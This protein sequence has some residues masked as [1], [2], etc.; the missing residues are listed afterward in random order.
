MRSR[1]SYCRRAI[2]LALCTA[3]VCAS[4]EAVAEP[5][6][7][8][9][10]AGAQI[11]TDKGCTILKVNFNL[12]VRY[13][14]HF[15]LN[16]GDELR[17]TVQPVDR[18]L[19]AA[20]IRVRREAARVADGTA[21]AIKTIDF[22]ADQPI[23]PVLRIVFEH[24]VAYQVAQGPD[25]ESIIIAIAG[26]RSSPTCRPEIP[27]GAHHARE[28]TGLRSAAA[29]ATPDRSKDRPA[30]K[31]SAANLRIV[32]ASMDEA[33][34]AMRKGQFKTAI[35]LFTKVLQYP[36][37]E[38]SAEAQELLG[39]AYQKSNELAQA[40]SEYED[41]LRRYPSG[42]GNERV[43]QR[44]ASILTA[45]GEPQEK[46]RKAKDPRAE[47]SSEPAWSLFGSVSAF[48]IR[49]DS[50]RM[51]KDPSLPPVP[52]EDKDEHRVHQNMM[53]SSIDLFGT[54]ADGQAK[55]KFRFSGSEEHSFDPDASHR[56]IT[57]VAALYAETLLSDWGLLGRVGRQT[58]NT[59]GVIGRFDGGLLSWQA[60]PA[61]RFNVVGGSPVASRR[62]TVF[63]DQKYFYG[64]SIDFGPLFGGIETSVFAIEQR[65]RSLLDRRSVG[66]EF[67]YFDVKTS[68]LGTVDY[69]VH[70]N[71]LNAAI[72]SGSWTLFDKST[73]Y[74][75]ADYRKA[76][77]LSAWTALQGQPFLT[78]YDMMR[79]YTKEEIDQ[80]AS[81]RTATYKS[82]MIGFSHPLNDK[83]QISADA[84]AVN[85]SGMP[86]SGGV[87]AILP[88]GNEYY[89]SLQ[90]I[91]TGIFAPGDMYIAGFRFA[92]L[93]QSNL[94][95]LDFSARYPLMPEFRISPRLR[96][97]YR[98]GDTTDLKEYTVLPSILL[99]YYLAKDVNLEL[100]VGTKWAELHQ[101]G[102]KETTTNLFLTAG[103]RYDFHVDGKA[104]VPA[105]RSRCTMPWPMC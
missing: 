69:D 92:D 90:L 79:L 48:Y 76:P 7:D 3:V 27:P 60:S 88:V 62:D 95:V 47:R 43:A 14:S 93:A 22:E 101:L 75:A 45:I 20:L 2:P 89:Y 44:L 72:F 34:A 18:S 102:T 35:P 73:I 66:A 63:K 78:L 103:L 38:H 94:Y 98:E 4:H 50:F 64:A 1:M 42:D 71:K 61:V 104:P 96:L 81:D 41:Y 39:L 52:N 65:D 28:Q 46:L 68:L 84:T 6:L 24:P 49:D 74:G 17:I 67:R 97:G 85:V 54:W 100:E 32:A 36:E 59:G 40:R 99:N 80:L 8:R 12:R 56:D 16:S 31:I 37:N 30:G 19:A 105:D 11:F 33:R 13:S 58:R 53:L 57:S 5:V 91:G 77:Y 15:P 21:T 23:G 25:F 83:L 87:D 51:L 86:A 70:F 10:L 29:P 55:S 9:A 26:K 82:A